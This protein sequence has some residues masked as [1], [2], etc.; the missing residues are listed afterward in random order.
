MKIKMLETRRATECGF[1]VKRYYKDF[2]YDVTEKF[3]KS[4]CAKGWAI[5]IKESK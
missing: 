4:I 3:G 2:T 1:F 5:E